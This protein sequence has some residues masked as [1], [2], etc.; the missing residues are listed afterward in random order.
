[1]C[2][3]VIAD[4][5]TVISIFVRLRRSKVLLDVLIDLNLHL[6]VT[7]CYGILSAIAIVVSVVI[8]HYAAF[9]S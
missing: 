4:K 6:T 5:F 7:N 8:C 1:M 2:V 9:L 3:Y